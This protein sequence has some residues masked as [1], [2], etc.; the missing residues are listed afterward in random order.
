MAAYK[1]FGAGPAGLYTAWRLLA[2]GKLSSEDSLEIYEWGDYDFE[3]NGG[4]RPPAGRICSHHYQSD[5]DNSY[6]EIG[7]MR[8]LEY[9]SAKNTGHQLVTKTIKL[10]GMDD[11]VVPFLTTDNPLFYLRG[12]HFY[13]YD[14]KGEDKGGDTLAPYGTPGVNA[15]A[16][17]DLFSN[18]SALLTGVNEL[19]SRSQ[20]CRFYAQG[21][22]PTEFNSF[23]YQGGET[24]SNLG[25]WNVFYDQAG[26]E[27]FNYAADAGGYS[28]NVINWNAADAAVY[29]GEFAPGGAF[30]TLKNGYSTLFSTLY[31]KA[32]SAA[33]EAGIPFRLTRK[34]RLHSIWLQSGQPTFLLADADN[35]DA[36][37]GNPA[38]A[39][40][41]FLAMP[42]AAV[43]LVSEATRYQTNAGKL[44]FLNNAKVRNYLDSVIEQPSYKIAM[45]FDAPWWT[46]TLYPPKLVS[47]GG[48]KNN[49]FGPTITDL[50]LRQVYYFGDNA[51][52]GNGPSIY[53][54]LA[55]YDDMRFIDFWRVME[56]SADQ[57]RTRAKAQDLQPLEGGRAATDTMQRMLML[58]LAKLHWDDP[59][60]T[61]KIPTPKETVYMDWSLNPFGA[62][63][64]A[65]AAHYDIC[66]VMQTIRTP[67]RLVDPD[68]TNVFL[69]GSAFSNDQ[70]WVEGAF[71]TAES[72]LVDYLGL[73]SIAD[74]ENYPL[75]C[76]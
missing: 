38:T 18:I 32:V 49:V 47:K 23:V 39:D 50:P 75:I 27:G 2:S 61:N 63:Y 66:D 76:G 42:P 5:P 28:S 7:G 46:D 48:A 3:G 15:K 51:P 44:D 45:F 14:L 65:W 55:S 26:N 22:L 13:Q 11:D 24:V 36:P 71:C 20:Q 53:G 70:A 57:R 37:S 35:S 30:K 60:A 67:A 52:T 25:Y 1:I 6:I 59:N 74:T 4:T 17:D 64:H 68:N 21:T 69:V 34:K 62:G 33:A 29:N 72:V 40:Y 9:D 43:D 8:F 12:K 56:V 16:A 10:L 54:I 31:E 58:Q 19:K 41:V 73:T